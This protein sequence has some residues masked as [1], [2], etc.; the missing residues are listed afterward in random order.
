MGGEHW[1]AH[2]L[3]PVLQPYVV[4]LL[5]AIDDEVSEVHNPVHLGRL[6]LQQRLGMSAATSRT[7]AVDVTLE[8]QM[9]QESGGASAQHPNR[10][11]A[12]IANILKPHVQR[13]T[14][15]LID[16]KPQ[17]LELYMLHWLELQVTVS[18]NSSGT[19]AP[20]SG[21]VDLASAS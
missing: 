17:N 1:V 7:H 2:C 10:K 19:S 13:L 11:Q 15:A 8:H 6:W 20:S 21:T 5:E 18:T 14:A 16:A 4:H 12:Y 9:P 3:Q